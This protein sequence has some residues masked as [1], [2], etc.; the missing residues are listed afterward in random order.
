MVQTDKINIGNVSFYKN[1]VKESSVQYKNGEKINC[2]F[3]KN[4]TKITFKDQKADARASVKT[5]AYAG[6]NDKLG[7][8]NGTGF[9]GIQG[10]T[11][12]GS[13]YDDFYHL[14][15]CDDFNVD[16]RGGGQ[17]EVRVF[18]NNGKH[19]NGQLKTD[20]NDATS[21]EDNPQYM[22]MNEGFFIKRK[23][24]SITKNGEPIHY[25]KFQGIN[26]EDLSH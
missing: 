23:Y 24:T 9:F 5:G 8:Q 3:L 6:G 22:N 1:D 10:L 26:P 14:F 20:G 13:N 16:T 15:N 2:V 17:D 7:I 25:Q 18:T 21:T 19:I 4:G 12:E 11:I